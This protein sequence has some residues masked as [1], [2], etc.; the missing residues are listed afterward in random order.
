[1]ANLEMKTLSRTA[2]GLLALTL[3]LT[4]CMSAEE[5]RRANLYQ[6]GNTCANFGSHYGSQSYTQCMLQQQQRRDQE[7][8]LAVET[9]RATSETSLNNLEVMRRLREGKR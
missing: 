5:Q 9:M 4:G 1:M 2:L 3:A 7:Q 8:L 6:D